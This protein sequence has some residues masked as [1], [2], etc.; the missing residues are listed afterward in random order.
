MLRI[1][2]PPAYPRTS[3]I[4]DKEAERD[5]TQNAYCDKESTKLGT[6]IATQEAEDDAKKKA[7][8]HEESAMKLEKQVAEMVA[9]LSRPW[10]R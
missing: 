5:A 9:M 8:F 10:Q 7:C 2:H 4:R 1:P 6:K 3:E